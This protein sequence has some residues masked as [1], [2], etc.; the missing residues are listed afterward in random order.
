MTASTPRIVVGVDGSAASVEALRWAVTQAELTSATIR[1]IATWR[2]PDEGGIAFYAAEIDW[3]DLT[4]RSLDIAVKE[5]GLGDRQD[6]EAVVLEGVP[7]HVLVE[8]S[9]DAQLLV[10]GTRGHGGFAGL[11][12]GSTSTYVIAHA[13]CPVVVVR[14]QA[15]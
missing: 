9:R 1:A 12:L 6:V 13:T 7:A 11:L 2:A 5:A 15:A 8:E 4:Q 3:V 10:V 14:D